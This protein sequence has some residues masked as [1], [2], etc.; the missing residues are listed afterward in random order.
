MTPSGDPPHSPSSDLPTPLPGDPGLHYSLLL[1]GEALRDGLVSRDMAVEALMDIVAAEGGRAAF[2]LDS[3]ADLPPGALLPLLERATGEVATSLQRIGDGE[4]E[5]DEEEGLLAGL[6][7]GRADRFQDFHL[8]GEGGMG[9][10]YDAFDPE[11]ERRVA[12]KFLRLDDPRVSA[13]EPPT[14]PLC[15][16][17]GDA[18]GRTAARR[19]RAAERFLREARITA[20]ITHPGVLAVYEIGLTKCGVP[21]YAMELLTSKLTLQKHIQPYGSASVDA[22]LRLVDLLLHVCD[23][24]D[25]AHQ[26]GIV[27]RDLKPANIGLA[28]ESTPYVL[29]WGLAKRL[30]EPDADSSES[31][32]PESSGTDGL[33]VDG[34]AI[35]TAPFWSPEAEEGRLDDIDARSD[36]YSLGAILFNILT[37]MAPPRRDKGVS[38]VAATAVEQLHSLQTDIPEALVKIMAEALQHDPSRRYRNAGTMARALRDWQRNRI[39]DLETEEWVAAARRAAKAARRLTG[40]DRLLAAHQGLVGVATMARRRP[41]HAEALQLADDLRA[42][43]DL[44]VQDEVRSGRIR[45]VLG[46]SALVLIAVTVASLF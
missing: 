14:S 7:M 10:V 26:A 32:E 21:Y 37:G 23:A 18:G 28:D 38:D 1:L 5:D 8:L 13:S 22:R 3:L 36:V 44:A 25:Q 6:V 27:H 20:S 31:E 12:V 19:H 45:L 43:R 29:D 40:R 2:I 46:V 4:R 41:H 39:V 16:N 17:P 11:L 42:L 15:I 9:T 24:V 34:R 33:T 35:G 30:G